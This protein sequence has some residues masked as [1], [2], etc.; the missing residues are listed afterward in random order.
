M[1]GVLK[2]EKHLLGLN[3]SQVSQGD[4]QA[5]HVFVIE[6]KY[7]PLQEAVHDDIVPVL[8][9]ATYLFKQVKHPE[10]E[11]EELFRKNLILNAKRI[12]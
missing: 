6:S 3:Y 9:L 7:N 4:E 10:L 1:V 11:H 8:K 5:T 2:Q 12:I